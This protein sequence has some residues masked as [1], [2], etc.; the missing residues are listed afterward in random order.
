MA[1]ENNKGWA[2]VWVVVGAI[3][4]VGGGIFLG[5]WYMASYVT[6]SKNDTLINQQ[7]IQDV[8]TRQ[9]KFS[10]RQRKDEADIEMLKDHNT[11]LQI[12]DSVKKAYLIK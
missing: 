4:A 3:G 10:D 11:K 5:I 9:E 1:D 12:I 7:A 6:S 8:R 2:K